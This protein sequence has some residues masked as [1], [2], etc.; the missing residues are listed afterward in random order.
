MTLTATTTEGEN[1]SSQTSTA[2]VEIVVDAQADRPRITGTAVG[3]EDTAI[4]FGSA[5]TVDLVDQDGSESITQIA[6][7]MP[8]SETATYSTVGGASV[9][10]VGQTY[11]IAGPEADIQATLD[12]FTWTPPAHSDANI[13]VQLQ[14][15][16][17]MPTVPRRHAPVTVLFV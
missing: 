15:L 16:P 14:R 1:G 9:N 2:P 10:V 8:G 7:T 5:Y 12:T 4:N 6:V 17:S 3:D 11:T 13:T